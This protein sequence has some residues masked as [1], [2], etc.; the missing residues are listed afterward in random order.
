M[1]QHLWSGADLKLDHARY[2]FE[3]M[4]KA[5]EPPAHTAMNV[6]LE[7]SGA[8]V[9]GMWHRAFYASLDAFL[10]ASRSI[11]EIVQ[12]CFGVDTGHPTMRDWFKNLDSGEQ[13]RRLKCKERFKPHYD[14]FRGLP[15]GTAR[16]ISEHRQGFAPVTLTITGR[17]GLTYV[18]DPITH[19]PMSEAGA[20]DSQHPW[21]NKSLAIRPKWTEFTIDGKPLFE[22]C[23]AYVTAAQALIN[24]GRTI[25]QAVNGNG[26]LSA[27]PNNL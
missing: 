2:Q 21:M 20:A 25:V 16:H 23:D 11:P 7:I 27:P 9:G 1:H 26:P 5:L 24:E 17:F 6:V 14:A 13:E 12:C 4:G 18:G 10:S 22:A 19:I 3:R 15:L 8:M